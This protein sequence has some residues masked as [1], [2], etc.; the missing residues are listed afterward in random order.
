MHQKVLTFYFPLPFS[1]G[2]SWKSCVNK[3]FGSAFVKLTV[4]AWVREAERIVCFVANCGG[5]Q[6]W[7]SHLGRPRVKLLLHCNQELCMLW[8]SCWLLQRDRRIYLE[9]SSSIQIKPFFCLSQSIIHRVVISGSFFSCLV[10]PTGSPMVIVASRP[11]VFFIV[12]WQN[13]NLKGRRDKE[14]K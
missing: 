12:A 2:S 13:L 8:V 4:W 11:N 9:K 1:A 10:I 14:R 6:L 7:F 3:I 5:F